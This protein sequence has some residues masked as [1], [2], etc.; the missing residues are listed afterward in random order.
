MRAAAFALL[1]MTFLASRTAVA[2]EYWYYCD[3]AGAYYPY[4]KTCSVPWRPVAPTPAPNSNLTPERPATAAPT[5]LT[6]SPQPA[7]PPVAPA[8][9]NGAVDQPPAGANQ[10]HNTSA[11]PVAK[12]DDNSIG[13]VLLVGATAIGILV[14]IVRIAA[15]RQRRKRLME[16]YGD[17]AAV[18]RIMNREIWQWMTR[19]QL[20]DSWGAPVDIGR[21]IYKKSI[22]EEFKYNQTG[23]NRFKNR[24]W[25]EN[26]IVVGWKE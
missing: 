14:F 19:D 5:P 22:R 6:P 8:A 23:R 11:V 21:Q 1:S 2:A 7:P 4:V 17:A 25:V 12:N 18:E 10:S 26:G 3:P 20:L 16:K 24:V 9:S 13:T 15:R